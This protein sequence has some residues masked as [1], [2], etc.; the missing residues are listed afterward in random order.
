MIRWFQILEQEF[1]SL[2]VNCSTWRLIVNSLVKINEEVLC[3]LF[4]LSEGSQH[5]QYISLITV[6]FI[7]SL[8]LTSCAEHFPSFFI[9]SVL[10]TTSTLLHI[11]C[12]SSYQHQEH[13]FPFIKIWRIC[14]KMNRWG[15]IIHFQHYN[16]EWLMM[17]SN[18]SHLFL[19]WMPKDGMDETCCRYAHKIIRI[20]IL[21]LVIYLSHIQLTLEDICQ[22]NVCQRSS[23]IFGLYE[24]RKSSDVDKKKIFCENH[25]LRVE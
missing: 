5:L 18:S 13:L 4:C 22:W 17:L 15:T 9:G 11:F 14:M 8:F 21:F 25:Y 12:T 19:S 20:S 24:W 6:L 3:H 23:S 7:H 2:S 10:L 1:V 16:Y